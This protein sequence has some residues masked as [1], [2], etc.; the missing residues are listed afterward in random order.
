MDISWLSNSLENPTI[1]VKERIKTLN[2]LIDTTIKSVR[3]ISSELR[4]G[5]LDDLGLISAIEWYIEEFQLRANIKCEL[6]LENISINFSN[7]TSIAIYRIV[8]ESLTNVA[9]HS[10]ASK[11][12]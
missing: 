2:S 10:K 7:D 9:R 12:K 8:Q 5:I 11:V 4:P 6:I 1:K 3:R